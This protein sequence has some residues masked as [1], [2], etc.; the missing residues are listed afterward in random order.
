MFSKYKKSD[1]PKAQAP[2]P[3]LE[4]VPAAEAAPKQSLMKAT[5]AELM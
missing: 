3:K 4:A 1:A 2:Q 5:Q